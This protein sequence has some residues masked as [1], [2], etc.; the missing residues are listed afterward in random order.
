M[1]HRRPYHPS[2]YPSREAWL[3]AGVVALCAPHAGAQGVPGEQQVVVTGSVVERLQRDAP[4]AISLVGAE[5][6][7]GAG[8]MVNLSEAMA[9]VPGLVVANRNNY[10][11]DLQ[12]SARGYGARAGFGV[13]G[14]RLVVDGIP[15]TMPDGQGQV[16]HAVL[17]NADRVEVLRGPYSVLYGNSSGGVIALVSGPARAGRAEVAADAGSFGLGQLRLSLATPLS[18]TLDVR[19]TVSTLEWEGFRPHASAHKTSGAVRLGWRDGDDQVVLHVNGLD[20]PAEDPL[21]LTRAQFDADERQTT[22]QATQFDTRKTTRQQQVGVQWKH[23]IGPGVETALMA[24]AGTRDVTQWLAITAATQA[25]P[26]HGGGVIDFARGYGGLD[27]RITWRGDAIDLVAGVAHDRQQDDRQGYLNYTGPATSPVYG[28]LGALRRDETN[29]ARSTDA[30]VQAEGR[31]GDALAWSAGVR[32]GRVSLQSADR[33]LANG[34]DSGA[35]RDAYVNPVLGLRWDATRALTLHA[36]AARGF[37]SPTLGELAYRP[38]GSGGFNTALKAQKSRQL[39]A[40]AKWRVGALAVDAAV[41]RIGTVDEIGVA[42]NSGGRQSFQN[43]GRTQRRGG[44][45]QLTWQPQRGWR[46]LVA[47]T[48]LDATTRDGFLTCAGIPC[49]APDLPVPAGSRIAGTQRTNLY[50]ELAWVPHANADIGIEVRHTSPLVANDANT[51]AAPA[52]TL[53]ALRA[54]HRH[55]LAPGLTLDVLAR[56]DNATGRRWVGSVIVNDANG[57]YY[58]PGTPRA[59]WLGLR[60]AQAF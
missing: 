58:E 20:Q 38:D 57:R 53:L 13:R 36:S 49:T 24:Y 41:F 60:L 28:G 50:G 10:A 31:V 43:I 21:G 46:G 14:V 26:R 35:R 3:A 5:A 59:V 19:A 1:P 44:E 39:E 55:T 17:A 9:R 54:R 34:D 15:A 22:S 12:I 37:E 45:L 56:L 16:S 52:T 18:P 47:A 11:Q 33:Y 7:R 48:W 29:R 40:G 8:P 6:L 51:E 23:R 25:V 30:Y 2:S 32:G 27:A 4:Y 42:T